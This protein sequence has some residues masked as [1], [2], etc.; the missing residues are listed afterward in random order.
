M[1]YFYDYWIDNYSEEKFLEVQEKRI[2]RSKLQ[3]E[4]NKL[5]KQRDECSDPLTL[6]KFNKSIEL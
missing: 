3:K 1:R 5:Q 2:I 4:L 6:D